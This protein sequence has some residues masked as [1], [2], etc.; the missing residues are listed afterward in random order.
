MDH[1]FL[2]FIN[3]GGPLCTNQRLEVE[4][5]RLPSNLAFKFKLRCYIKDRLPVDLISRLVF[6]LHEDSAS[7]LESISSAHQRQGLTLVHIFA[8]R[9]PFLRDTLGTCSRLMQ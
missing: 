6:D 4:F 5:D 7:T 1:Y 2:T 9:K 8:Q 3:G